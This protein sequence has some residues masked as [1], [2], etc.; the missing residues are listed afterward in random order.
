VSAFTGYLASL[1]A[2][3]YGSRRQF[4]AAAEGAAAPDPGGSYLSK[5]LRGLT[6]PP[7]RRLGGWARA[8]GLEGEEAEHFYDLALIAHLPAEFQPRFESLLGRVRHCEARLK[9]M[10]ADRARLERELARARRVADAD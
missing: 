8:L 7:M 9:E 2:A 5:V 1:I 6:P 4:V 3:K 10:D